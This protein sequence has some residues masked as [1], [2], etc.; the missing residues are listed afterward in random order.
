MHTLLVVLLVLDGAQAVVAGAAFVHGRARRARGEHGLAAYS[1]R[2]AG[3][4]LVGAFV[5]GVPLVLGL[6]GVLS[7]RTAVWVVVGAEAVGVVAARVVLERL[8]AAAHG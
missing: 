6:A 4:L 5:L 3:L 2:H 1:F 7:T 8:H